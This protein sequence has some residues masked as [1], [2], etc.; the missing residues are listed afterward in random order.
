MH[1]IST[2]SFALTFVLLLAVLACQQGDTLTETPQNR[3]RFTVVIDPAHG[4]RDPG[5]L[6]KSNVAEKDIALSIANAVKS[7]LESEDCV[8]FLTRTDDAFVSLE[9]RLSLAKAAAADILLS[10]HTNV[11]ADQNKCGLTTFY[12]PEMKKSRMLD[13]LFHAEADQLAPMTDLGSQT[14]DFTILKESI[15]P[16][17]YVA[18][19]YLSNAADR[20]LLSDS[21]FQDRAAGTIANCVKAYNAATDE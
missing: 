13:G 20:Q 18:L 17:L 19:G 16:T 11:S 1:K 2:T 6:A 15:C 3:R 21:L 8:V 5:A 10:I 9:Q 4:G 7:K 12:Y 14:A